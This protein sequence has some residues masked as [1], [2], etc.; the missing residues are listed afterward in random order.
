MLFALSVNWWA[1]ALRGAAAVIFGLLALFLPGVTLTV[2]ILVFGA[3]ALVDGV[4]AIV[5]GVRGVGPRWLLIVEGVI[6]VLFGILTFLWPVITAFVLLYFIAF[7]AIL[8][9]ALE[10]IAAIWLRREIE[11]EWAL[12]A[13][14]VFSVIFGLILVLSPGLGLLSLVWLIG[15]YALVFGVVL[16]VLAFRVRGRGR[17]VSSRVT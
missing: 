8:T 3:Y 1:L 12:I 10:I 5:A 7:W 16:I 15:V 17:G 6:G 13:G 14:G 2:L 4:L 11:G 9:D